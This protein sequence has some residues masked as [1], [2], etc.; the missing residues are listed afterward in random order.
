MATA[1]FDK[2]FV[3]EDP[4]AQEKLYDIIEGKKRSKKLFTEIY[5]LEDKKRSES[6]LK[7]LVSILRA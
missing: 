1:T 4:V 7:Q 5:T 6:A 2:T 3:I